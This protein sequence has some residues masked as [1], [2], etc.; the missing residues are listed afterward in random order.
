MY[1]YIHVLVLRRLRRPC[2]VPVVSYEF[3]VLD[4]FLGGEGFAVVHSLAILYGYLLNKTRDTHPPMV[5]GTFYQAA[6]LF[7]VPGIQYSTTLLLLL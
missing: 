2:I 1:V 4:F 5:G 6:V 3:Y 7:A